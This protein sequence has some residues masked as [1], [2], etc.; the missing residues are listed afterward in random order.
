MIHTSAGAEK[1][2]VA[3]EKL[4]EEAVLCTFRLASSLQVE[5]SSCESNRTIFNFT[6]I[7][8]LFVWRI[9]GTVF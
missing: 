4:K 7:W 6:F 8:G 5:A 9:G 3:K 2:V 1:K